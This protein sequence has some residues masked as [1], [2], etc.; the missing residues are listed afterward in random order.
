MQKKKREAALDGLRA[1]PEV[2]VGPVDADRV[3]LVTETARAED[4]PALFAALADLP[5]VELLH[6][7]FH[8]FSDVGGV[9]GTVPKRFGRKRS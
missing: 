6:V 7:V 9:E 5:G 4:D 1:R 8:D 2:S 3:A